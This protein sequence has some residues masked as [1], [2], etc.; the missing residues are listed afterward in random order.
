ML[1]EGGNTQAMIKLA[2]LT[3][4]LRPLKALAEQGDLTAA[5]ALSEQL[6]VESQ[7]KP[8]ACKW[9]CIAANGGNGVAQGR[10]GHWHRTVAWKR[11]TDLEWLRGVVGVRPDN[12]VAYMWYMLADSS[13]YST[14]SWKLVYVERALTPDEIAQAK[15]MFRDWK[16]G[17]CPSAEHWLD[18]RA[19]DSDRVACRG[20]S[21]NDP[22]YAQ[23]AQK[24][25]ITRD[26]CR[27]ID[28][29]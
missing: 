5:Y 18:S 29:W 21:T 20:L 26:Y 11:S 16:P 1:A 28:A 17:D 22:K 9:L 3:G 25:N 12:R 10:V 7:T 6:Q 23:E 14:A 4:D 13:G 2:E 19:T 15:Q 8:E 24:R 27:R